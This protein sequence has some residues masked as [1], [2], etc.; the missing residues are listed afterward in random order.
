MGLNVNDEIIAVDGYRVSELDKAMAQKKT[1]ETAI[2]LISRD[3]L[4][5]N[6]D[7]KLTRNP[8]LKYKIVPINNP[9]AKQ[10]AIRTKWLNLEEEN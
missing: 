1:G 4:I 7:V 6:L 10:L 5:L 2:I 8:T 3:G 9:S